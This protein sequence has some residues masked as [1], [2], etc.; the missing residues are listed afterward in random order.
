MDTVLNGLGEFAAAFLD[1]VVIFSTS[2]EN[3][4]QAV[5]QRIKDAGLTINPVKY[6]LVK[7]ETEYLG[8]VLGNGVIKLQVQKAKAIQSCPLPATKKQIRSF[9]GLVGWYWKF[10]PIFRPSLKD[11]IKKMNPNRVQWTVPT[12]K[13]FFELKGLLSDKP[14]FCSPD[15]EKLFVLQTDASELGLG[16]VMM[17]EET[18]VIWVWNYFQEKLGI[19]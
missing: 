5:F 1:D 12:E 3:Y 8:S 16:A 15:L 2:W 17:Q 19:R 6:S 9:V 7:T 14:I 10:I 18:G 4:L 13:A 11:L